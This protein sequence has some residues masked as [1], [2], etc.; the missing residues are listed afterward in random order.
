[1][2]VGVFI[3]V[4]LILVLASFP[5][6]GSFLL[7]SI[8]PSVVN[9][10]FMFNI[11]LAFRAIV[12]GMN[13]FPILA[14][15]LFI[16]GG[17][18]MA[19][20][21][22]SEALFRFFAYFMGNK[23]A[24]YPCAVIV[25]CL[26]YGAISG[27]GPA[28]TAAV[29]SMTLP[30][31]FSMNYDRK[32]S[33]ALV[34]VSGALGIII[35]PSIPFIIYSTVTNVSTGE[36]FIAGIMP[37]ILIGLC[38]MVYAYYYCWKHGEDKKKLMENYNEIRADGFVRVFIHSLPALLC[39]VI[40]LGSIYGGIASPTEA[41]AVSVFYS[42]IVSLFIYKNVT[43][44]ELPSIM[45]EGIRNIAPILFII[46]CAVAFSRVM[47]LMKV[48]ALVQNSVMSSLSSKVAILIMINVVLLFVGMLMDTLPAIMIFGPIFYPLAAASGVNL[49]HF[50]VIMVVNLAIGQATPPMGINLFVTS[51]LTKI[52]VLDLAKTALPFLFC[53]LIALIIITFVPQVS[54][55]FL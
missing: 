39:P 9:P 22:V 54:L 48:P 4:F 35:P 6:A 47:T 5:I 45:A 8:V 7:S 2:S 55:F 42:L 34:G 21:G 32:F 46:A 43:W 49:L 33:A 31:L 20:G 38:L 41:A 10:G 40:V 25:T 27:S 28:T 11:Q 52:P 12:A 16:L 51:S 24:G 18:I 50:G 15:P 29:G 36:L 37:G 53:F 14:I 30:I 3:L 1:M 23:R 19:R 26:F 13:S 44:R 17:A